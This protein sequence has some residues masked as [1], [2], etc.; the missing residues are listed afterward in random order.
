MKLLAI[1]HKTAIHL[2]V[3]EHI[4]VPTGKISLFE[5]LENSKGVFQF[6]YT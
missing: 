3:Y 2:T 5:A 1:K 6:P 4:V